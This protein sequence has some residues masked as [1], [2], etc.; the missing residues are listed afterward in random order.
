MSHIASSSAE[1][2][3]ALALFGFALCTIYLYV[4]FGDSVAGKMQ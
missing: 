1:F 2:A 4:A 3:S